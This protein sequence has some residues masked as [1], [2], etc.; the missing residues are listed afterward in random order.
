VKKILIIGATSSIAEFTARLW[1]KRGYELFLIARNKA[2]LDL[3]AS[4]LKIRG[5]SKVFIFVMDVNNFVKHEVMFKEVKEKLG[6]IDILFVA[7]GSLPDQVKCEKSVE[8]TIHEINNNALSV[9]ALLTIA[10]NIFEQQKKGTIA[11]ISSVAGDRGRKSNYIYGSTKA[12]VTAF[13]SGLRQRLYKCDVSVLTIK[14][15]LVDTPMTKSFEKN[16]LWTKPENVAKKIFNSI[17][18]RKNILYVPI[19][20]FFIMFI[21]KS[22]P[23]AIFKKI[24][25][26]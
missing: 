5:A 22:I 7:H 1:A 12:M 17:E 20:W 8:M 13:M 19:F 4:D 15:G 3:I 21:I 14:P 16:F 2:R 18:K 10:A 25:K 23:E 26:L 6:W 11:V 9:I 24:Q